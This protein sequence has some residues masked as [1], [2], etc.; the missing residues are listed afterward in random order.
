M[1]NSRDHS[2]ASHSG[3]SSNRS[4]SYD[5]VFNMK[6]EEDELLDNQD[7]YLG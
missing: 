6:E 2:R 7:D 1:K 5:L 4:T 3:K